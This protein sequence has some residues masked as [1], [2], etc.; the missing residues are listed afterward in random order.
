MRPDEVYSQV[1]LFAD[2]TALY[3]TMEIEIDGPTFQNDMGILSM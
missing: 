2:D 3:L 1:L